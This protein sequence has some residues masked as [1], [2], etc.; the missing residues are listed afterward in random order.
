[1]WLH[2][3]RWMLPSWWRMTSFYWG[4][5]ELCDISWMVWWLCE[6][7]RIVFLWDVFLVFS[8]AVTIVLMKWSTKIYVSL[9]KKKSWSHD[10]Q[11]SCRTC[12]THGAHKYCQ[13]TST[14]SSVHQINADFPSTTRGWCH[15]SAVRSHCGNCWFVRL[16]MRSP[17]DW[18]TRQW[19]SKPNLITRIPWHSSSNRWTDNGIE[20]H[21]QGEQL[22]STQGWESGTHRQYFRQRSSPSSPLT[23]MDFQMR[24]PGLQD[25]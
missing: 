25:L 12:G 15:K 2:R 4:G 23:S 5:K 20:A 10:M 21:G 17:W 24:Q 6:G 19:I 18:P 13:H 7:Y 3:L 9:R 16:S 22:E 11:Y 14:D 1:M 8:R